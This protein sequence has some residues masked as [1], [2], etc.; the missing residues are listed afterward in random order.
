MRWLKKKEMFPCKDL[1]KVLNS[2]RLKNV[3]KPFLK[4]ILD[5]VFCNY[6]PHKLW[7]N[8]SFSVPLFS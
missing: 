5:R 7:K 6:L 8:L 3:G 4:A 1:R 2:F